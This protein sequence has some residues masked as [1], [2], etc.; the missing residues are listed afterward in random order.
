M[1]SAWTRVQHLLLRPIDD[2]SGVSASLQAP[3][4]AAGGT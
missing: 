1:L 3:G 4:A 2:S